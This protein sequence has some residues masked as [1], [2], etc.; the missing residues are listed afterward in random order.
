MSIRAYLSRA[1]VSAVRPHV[2][3]PRLVA[4][5]SPYSNFSAFALVTVEMGRAYIELR[6]PVLP[7]G[8]P[9]EWFNEYVVHIIISDADHIGRMTCGC[10][11]D[12]GFTVLSIKQMT[13]RGGDAQVRVRVVGRVLNDVSWTMKRVLSGDPDLEWLGHYSGP[14]PALLEIKRGGSTSEEGA[15]RVTVDDGVKREVVRQHLA[16]L[17]RLIDTEVHVGDL[18]MV[19]QSEVLAVAEILGHDIVPAEEDTDDD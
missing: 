15:E 9:E 13:G 6:T 12:K 19:M 18:Y 2:E 3:G 5:K 17:Y 14:A 7:E 1:G 11:Q 16:E 4:C 10:V 8:M